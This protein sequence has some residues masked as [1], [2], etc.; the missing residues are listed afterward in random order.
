MEVVSTKKRETT[1]KVYLSDRQVD[2]QQRDPYV[3]ISFTGYTKRKRYAPFGNSSS[4][5]SICFLSLINRSNLIQL[6][7]FISLYG[8]LLAEVEFT[9][10]LD[11]SDGVIGHW[12]AVLLI[13]AVHLF[14]IPLQQSEMLEDYT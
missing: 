12:R 13:P 7:S 9:E 5:W 14:W 8:V 2:S 6:L 11:F 3:S 10:F 1:K 4:S